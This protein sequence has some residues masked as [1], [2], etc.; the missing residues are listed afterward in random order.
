MCGG[1][2]SKKLIPGNNSITVDEAGF[3]LF[4]VPHGTFYSSS[5]QAIANTA[6]TQKITF[7]K[8]IDVER[9]IHSTSVNTSRVYVPTAGSY[10][11]LFSG[12]ADI[13]SGSPNKH[14]EVWLAVDGTPQADT[15]TRVEIGSISIETT[16]AVSL[17]V[18]LNAGQYIELETWGDATT[19]E[20]LATAAGTGPTRPACPSVIMTVKKVSS[21]IS[22]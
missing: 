11:I 9:L 15:N 8:E 3:V 1:I 16:V 10:E 13:A 21:R 7:E 5:T 6:N 2:L 19:C 18:D 4:K 12:I 17:I 14:I 22:A 20:W